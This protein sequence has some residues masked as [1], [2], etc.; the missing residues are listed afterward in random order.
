MHLSADQLRKYSAKL[1]EPD[2]LL[3]VDA[4]LSDCSECRADLAMSSGAK[5][6]SLAAQFLSTDE[7]EHLRY[8]Q[9]VQFMESKDKEGSIAMHLKACER[10]SREFLDL[11]GFAK[12][13][14]SDR[15]SRP[16]FSRVLAA[17]AVLALIAI[18]AALLFEQRDAQQVTMPA[19]VRIMVSLEEPGTRITLDQDGKLRGLEGV[20]QQDQ[21]MVVQALQTRTV[22]TPASLH[23]FIGERGTLRGNESPDAFR[24][25][26]PSGTF[27]MDDQPV[28]RWEILTGASKY[29]VTILDDQLNLISESPW[30]QETSWKAGKA[31][32]RNRTL[33]WQVAA[34]RNGVDVVSPKPPSPEARFRIL[35]Q[36]SHEQLRTEI[37]KS[38][39][40][41]LLLG[42]LYARYG[43][44]DEAEEHLQL[45]ANANP[46]SQEI[47]QLLQALKKSRS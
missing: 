25:L 38:R 30:I 29:K 42:L 28:F 46:Q 15:V 12:E 22:A 14:D 8:D 16:H 24:V 35:D 37:E 20:P 32:P 34:S 31:L 6:E 9:L 19:P 44:L 27:V 39:N 47:S 1:L 13:L 10:C 43:L 45:V 4:H 23:E 2:E 17:A 18:G 33:I 40:S 41:N 7:E 3:K 5:A 36:Q 11:Q 21:Q 26:S